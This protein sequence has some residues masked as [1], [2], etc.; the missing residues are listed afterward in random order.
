MIVRIKKISKYLGLTVIL[1]WPPVFVY[2]SHY[3][4]KAS[5][6]HIARQGYELGF[7]DEQL[8]VFLEN[9]LALEA[10]RVLKKSFQDKM[11]AGYSVDSVVGQCRE[12]STLDLSSFKIT[13]PQK[14]HSV[15]VEGKILD[16]K[17]SHYGDS[18]IFMVV[19]RPQG[20]SIYTYF[21][22]NP[23]GFIKSFGFDTLIALWLVFALWS[24][25]VLRNIEDVRN[26]YRKNHT[27]PFWFKALNG[28]ASWLESDDQV[29]L[30]KIHHT[31]KK[32]L[33]KLVEERSYYADTLE[34]TLLNDFAAASEK[35]TFPYSFTGTVARVDINGY[36]Q[37]IYEGNRPYLLE[38]KKVFEWTAAEC[39]YRYQGLFE[40]RAG[41]MVVY[42]FKGTQ[43]E[44]RA[45]AF[46]RDFSLEFSSHRFDFLNHKGIQLFVKSSVATSN[47]VMA[48][49]PSKYDFDGDALYLTDRM[50]GELEEG[51]KKINVLVLFPQDYTK[52]SRLVKPS[53]LTK[54]ISRKEA[55]LEV[56][57]HDEFYSFADSPILADLFVGNQALNEQMDFF[58]DTRIPEKERNDILL[59]LLR[60]L[61]VKK[62]P[63][64]LSEAWYRTLV[65]LFK[66][67]QRELRII[68][69]IFSLGRLLVPPQNWSQKFSD[70]IVKHKISLDIRSRANAIELV[71][72]WNDFK[73]IDEIYEDIIAPESYRMQ[74]NFVLSRSLQSPSEEDFKDIIAMIK[75]SDEKLSQ[76]GIFAG[77]TLVITLADRNISELVTFNGF[78]KLVAVLKT[79]QGR[80]ERLN[81]L[82]EKALKA[83]EF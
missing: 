1:F 69:S 70:L 79:S 2:L 36:G 54:N 32:Q 51:D 78:H 25:F 48:A 81:A 62:V 20:Q 18:A 26:L 52:V 55:T 71:A 59:V 47:L 41:D 14:I 16:Y 45:V 7:L 8:Q 24:V 17:L 53:Y 44:E 5:R 65:T 77:A 80:S 12:P 9:D 56:S 19:S 37:Y 75:S 73:T 43:A 49:S 33:S 64:E 38:M 60:E 31:Q 57:Y 3:A 29:T 10:C 50:F 13:E 34:Y 76:S 58:V 6:E 4:G 15:E 68:A 28:L 83:S 63:L 74:A 46:V 27:P 11:I 66:A 72:N 21:L 67:D 61:R 30:S 22:M 82:I 35:I 40:G 42:V 23:V 39:A